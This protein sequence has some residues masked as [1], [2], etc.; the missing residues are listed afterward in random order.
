VAD[1]VRLYL[2]LARAEYRSAGQHR[3]SFALLGLASTITVA[4][5]FVIIAFLL[6]RIPRL[7]GFTL[8]QLGV[9]Y[10]LASLAE[11]LADLA[12]GDV[13]KASVRVKDGTFDTLLLRPG[14]ALIQ[15]AAGSCRPQMLG[16]PLQ[17]AVIL[18]VALSRAG[19]D[20]TWDR[21][22]LLPATVLCGTLI[23]VAV[24]VAGAALTFA[25]VDAKE[26]MSAF[27]YGG[28]YLAQYPLSIYATW[29]RHLFT[30]VLPIAFVSWFPA[31]HLLGV[32]DPLG[33][34]TWFRFAPPVAAAAS[35]AVATLTWRAAVRR[36]R[37]TGS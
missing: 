37:S 17:A 33:L 13:E 15:L 14:P 5:D 24:W 10:G 30:Y 9:L 35:L 34:P 31:L 27:T 28:G 22:L 26:A 7:A 25:T 23:F 16:R 21:V 11:R 1:A 2:V 20:W 8:A 32:P 3:A 18:A 6:Q 4:L 12:V 29:F 19:V 36:Y